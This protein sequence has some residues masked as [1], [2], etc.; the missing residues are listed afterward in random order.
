MKKVSLLYILAACLM[1]CAKSLNSEAAFVEKVPPEKYTPVEVGYLEDIKVTVARVEGKNFQ[2]GSTPNNMID[3]NLTTGYHSK[4]DNTANDYWPIN[5]DFYFE[6]TDLVSSL[7]YHPRVSGTNGIFK[8][9]EIWFCTKSQPELI[10]LM[11]FNFGGSSQ[12]TKVFF[13]TAISNP[14]QIRI[15]VKSGVSNLAQ[16]SEM[17]FYRTNEKNYDP[18]IL[19]QDRACTTLKAGVTKK[20]IE[21]IPNPFFKN[22]A[23]HIF[24]KTYDT[25]YRIES[26]K[27]FAH[28]QKFAKEYKISTYSVRDNP[29]GIFVKENE[30]L[31]VMVED[32]HGQN[33]SLL[34]QDLDK[35]FGGLSYSLKNGLNVIK[36]GQK[37]LIYVMYYTENGNE[38][39]VK[40]HIASGSINGV[41]RLGKHSEQQYQIMLSNAAC[42]YFDIIGDYAHLTFTVSDL[43]EQK[44]TA[45]NLINVYEDIVRLEQEF[46]GLMKYHQR[47]PNHMYFMMDI[48][49][50][51]PYATSFRTAYPRGSMRLMCNAEKLRIGEECWGAA[52]E[53]GHVNQTRPGFKWIGM[54]EVSNN[55]MSLYVQTRLAKV[56][57]LQERDVYL[58]AFNDLKNKN[59][60]HCVSKDLFARL[61]PF[62]QL[63]L[64]YANVKGYDDFYKD[65]YEAIRVNPNPPTD[66]ECQLAFIKTVCQIAK[67]DLTEFFESWG[68]LLPVQMIINDYGE[69]EMLITPLMIEQ[70][71]SEIRAM[72]L[73]KP[74]LKVQDIT[75]NTVE[76]YKSNL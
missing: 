13:P 65:L 20:D 51:S 58:R 68:M 15:I 14:T 31:V 70:V 46:L 23:T 17:E 41:Y 33:I 59:I 6:D 54:T 74:A 18:S 50:K 67:E 71:R 16:C 60:P 55:V 57:R 47:I 56:S 25:E 28:P 10:K 1:G 45:E 43:L 26:Y 44:S 69:R 73:P 12:A 61:V 5:L 22:L 9:V 4:W 21:K 29:T 32:T 63:Q 38:E 24:N 62:W 72:N 11:D 64:Y 48:D 36:T 52:H 39:P 35:G 19:F 42:P 8:E 66:G 75:D 3:G 2:P 53:V 37:G 76:T 30:E 49:G 27:P 34:I 7:I 40:I